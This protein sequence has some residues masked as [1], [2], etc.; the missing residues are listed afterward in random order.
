MN[1]LQL[2]LK[3]KTSSYSHHIFER[4]YFYIFPTDSSLKKK[5]KQKIHGLEV[6]NKT[7]VLSFSGVMYVN[8]FVQHRKHQ[9]IKNVSKK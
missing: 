6:S 1:S 2:A 9:H 4:K 8:I 5:S 3:K 7:G